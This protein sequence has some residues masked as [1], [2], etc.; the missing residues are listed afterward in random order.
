MDSKTR[1]RPNQWWHRSIPVLL[2]TALAARGCG[3]QRART[4]V[5]E[6]TV[7]LAGDRAI[8]SGDVQRHV[9]R[10]PPVLRQRYASAEKRK[11]VLQALVQNEV[12]L[13]EARRRGLDRDPEYGH[14]VE[15]KL[16]TLLLE[17]ALAHDGAA[18]VADAE[19]ERFC[20]EHSAEFTASERVQVSQIVLADRDEALKARA[21]RSL[22]PG[23]KDRF[24]VLA[25]KHS[26]DAPSRERGGTWDSWR[27]SAFSTPVCAR[28]PSRSRGPGSFRTSSRPSGVLFVPIP[29]SYHG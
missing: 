15:Q 13:Q 26:I 25:A 29:V 8:T 24:S 11:P 3:K 21:A 22:R 28:P 10:L 12:L 27:W 1:R 19:A 18:S 17:R 7:A 6:V 20:R 14:S 5:A 2:G 16:T 9:D 4:P 23:D